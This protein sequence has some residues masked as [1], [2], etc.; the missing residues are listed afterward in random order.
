VV[1]QIGNSLLA[2][3][4]Y[5]SAAAQ[6]AARS[7]AVRRPDFEEA[8]KEARE[9]NSRPEK[10]RSFPVDRV[11][12]RA[13]EEAL[14]TEETAFAVQEEAQE[15]AADSASRFA[16]EAP[17]TEVRRYELPGSRLDISI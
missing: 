10:A 17:G 7:A 6:K 1:S 3:Q 11:D 13:T 16:R 9:L 4:M 8:A 12:L 15:A 5:D 2:A 14:L